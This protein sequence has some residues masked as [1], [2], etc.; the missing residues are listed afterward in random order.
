MAG[1]RTK[2]SPRKIKNLSARKASPKEARGIRGGYIGETEK[3]KAA[4]VR[5][6]TSNT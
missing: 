4:G 3:L 2:S 1:K 6:G 5:D